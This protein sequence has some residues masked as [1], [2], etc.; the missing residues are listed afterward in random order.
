MDNND[1]QPDNEAPSGVTDEAPESLAHGKASIQPLHSDTIPE[2]TQLEPEALT[3][4][5][6]VKSAGNSIIDSLPSPKNYPQSSL[7]KYQRETVPTKSKRLYGLYAL[8]IILV[9]NAFDIFLLSTALSGD[10]AN[11]VRFLSA[12][13]LLM[14]VGLLMRKEFARIL[15]IALFILLAVLS[16]GILK[17]I[18]FIGVIIYLCMPK[19]KDEFGS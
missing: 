6:N 7:P 5:D 17:K 15:T 1:L 8:V 3:R 16:F 12:I 4:S 2:V 19:V 11:F 9:V 13:G 10:A 14:G 18:L